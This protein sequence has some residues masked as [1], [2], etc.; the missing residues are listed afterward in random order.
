VSKPQHIRV[1]SGLAGDR[2]AMTLSLPN[3]RATLELW[4]TSPEFCA[5]RSLT[6]VALAQHLLLLSKPANL[7]CSALAG[8]YSRSLS[9]KLPGSVNP[10]LEVYACFWQ[11]PSKHVRMAARSLFHC[12]AS[13]AIPSFLQLDMSTNIP[14]SHFENPPKSESESSST[15]LRHSHSNGLSDTGAIAHITDW[16]QSYDGENWTATIGGTTQDARAARII[17]S[18][19]LALW[20]PSLVQPEVAPTVAPMLLNL[21]R[22]THD[23]HSATAADVLAEGME[24]T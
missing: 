19:A 14:S 8:F 13:R 16:I 15:Y 4:K 10:C 6:N 21:V 24:S 23:R 3:Q 1:G 2:G 5:L 7:A 9:E 20:Y 17:V 12:A 22:A 11:D 18:A